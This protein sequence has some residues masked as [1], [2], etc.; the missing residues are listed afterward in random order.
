MVLSDLVVSVILGA[1]VVFVNAKQDVVV[2]KRSIEKAFIVNQ[3]HFLDG[4][5]SELGVEELSARVKGGS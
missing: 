5:R 2:H 3:N 1:V 4:Q